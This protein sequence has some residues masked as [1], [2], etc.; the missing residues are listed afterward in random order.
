MNPLLPGVAGGG[1]KLAADARR[2][3]RGLYL[4]STISTTATAM[5]FSCLLNYG[6]AG[7][8]TLFICS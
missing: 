4:L 8:S 5:I 6:S 1:G 2:E 3:G 7:P